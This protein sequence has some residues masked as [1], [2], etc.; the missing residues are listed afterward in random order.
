MTRIYL[1][2]HGE[3]AAGFSDH[4]DPGLSALGQQQ[5]ET[6]AQS[7][8]ALTGAVLYSSPLARA[9][10]TAAPLE[11][12]RGVKAGIEP[13]LAEIPSPSTDLAERAQWLGAAMAGAWTAL[14]QAQQ[15]FRN[16]LVARL[17][18]QAEDAIFFSHFV[19]IN[20]AV[21][22]AMG[23]TRMHIFSP[24]NASVTELAT[25]GQSLQLVGL[26]AEAQTRVN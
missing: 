25:D 1:V 20:L 14:P 6:V 15:A 17:L 13:A 22:A 2:R 23:D 9:R 8:S 19:A 26:G 3:A 11:T 16:A 5:A 4:K 7:L 18:E 21:G 10:E 24:T 12:L